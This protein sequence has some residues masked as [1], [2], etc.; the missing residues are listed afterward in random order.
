MIDA[1]HEILPEISRVGILRDS[2][3]SKM[4]TF[5][6]KCNH[7]YLKAHNQPFTIENWKGY[8]NYIANH[9]RWMTEDRPDG[10]G[11][12]WRVKNIDYLITD[13]CYV[14]VKEDRANDRC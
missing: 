9:C 2:R 3:K 13:K 1:Y 11:G 10:K 7:E 8:L 6:Q 12:Y 5:W 4:R 14:S